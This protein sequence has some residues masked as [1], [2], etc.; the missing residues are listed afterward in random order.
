MVLNAIFFAAAH[1]ALHHTESPTHPPRPASERSFPTPLPRRC[2]MADGDGPS[3]PRRFP[4]AAKC[5]H[6]VLTG[7]RV[8]C[9]LSANRRAAHKLA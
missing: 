2:G 1:T 3:P 8:R 6:R 7:A 4:A 9:M 5:L